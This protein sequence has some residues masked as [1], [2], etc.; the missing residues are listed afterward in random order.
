MVRR[1]R[2][3]LL[4]PAPILPAKPT[5]KDEKE[6]QN[7]IPACRRDARQ[8][9]RWFQR[10]GQRRRRLRPRL[11]S[12]RLWRLPPDA[13]ARRCPPGSDR[14]CASPCR[15]RAARAR[16]PL[17][18]PLV[19]RP[20]PSVLISFFALRNGRAAKACAAIFFLSADVAPG[21]FESERGPR[22][23]SP[24]KP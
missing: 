8:R 12:R 24:F 7:E 13:P 17:R 22:S 9:G 3:A 14:G 5:P 20:L 6:D 11:V 10:G 15:G 1:K 4:V 19:R 18:L 23:R 21:C 2:Q 16:V